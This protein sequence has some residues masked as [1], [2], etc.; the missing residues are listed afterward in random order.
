MNERSYN[1]IEVSSMTIKNQ[2]INKMEETL[3]IASDATR[4]KILFC[5]LEESDVKAPSDCGCGNPACHCGDESRPF[6]EKC[7]NDIA[8]EVNCSQSLVSH[9][10][11]VLKDGNFVKSRK[12]KTRI[13]YSL[14]DAHVREIIKI[15]FE[16]VTEDDHE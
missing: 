9:Q 11:K 8:L 2:V 16:H 14:K 5:L 15:T 6:I 12:E 13:Y 1:I 10:L 7:V 4:L 3:K